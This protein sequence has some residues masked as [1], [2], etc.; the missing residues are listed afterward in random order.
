MLQSSSILSTGTRG[1]F[2]YLWPPLADAQEPWEQAG[3]EHS[4][5][6]MGSSSCDA[7]LR[8]ARALPGLL[9]LQRGPASSPQPG[10][11]FS[12]FPGVRHCGELVCTT[13]ML[14]STELLLQLLSMLICQTLQRG[15]TKQASLSPRRKAVSVYSEKLTAKAPK[16]MSVLC[17]AQNR[18]P[19]GTG[20][21]PLCPVVGPF[22]HSYGEGRI[23]IHELVSSTGT[24]CNW[25]IMCKT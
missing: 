10:R 6:T 5:P 11:S 17:S 9:T 25:D 7:D 14:H 8:E 23:F 16:A 15:Q 4:L 3:A 22:S 19:L 13:E 2:R 18:F 1:F 12:S 20:E 21:Q 24:C